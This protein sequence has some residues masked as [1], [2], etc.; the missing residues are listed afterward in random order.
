LAPCVCFALLQFE[1]LLA[2]LVAA[3]RLAIV[4]DMFLLDPA[5]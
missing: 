5:G 2:A 3:Q 1:L 4:L